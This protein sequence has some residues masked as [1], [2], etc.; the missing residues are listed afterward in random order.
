MKTTKKSLLSSATYLQSLAL[1]GGAAALLSSTAAFAQDAAEEDAAS[2]DQTIV[3][4]VSLIRN[5]NLSSSAPV[6]T[7]GTQ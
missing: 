7:I 2:A 4:T 6:A 5:Q 1:V 3:V